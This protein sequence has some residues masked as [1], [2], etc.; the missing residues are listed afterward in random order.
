MLGCSDNS[1][2]YTLTKKKPEDDCVKI[3]CPRSGSRTAM[4]HQI[5]SASPVIVPRA[6]VAEY[7]IEQFSTK[8]RVLRVE[9]YILGIFQTRTLRIP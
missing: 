5:G 2:T 7:Q 8:L 4:I 3:L 6:E 1:S 9:L